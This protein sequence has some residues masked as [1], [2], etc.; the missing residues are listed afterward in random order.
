MATD[1][2]IVQALTAIRADL[3]AFRVENNQRFTRVEEHLQMLNG[4]TAKVET[5]A[6][7]LDERTS[8]MACMQHS[9][10]FG[11]ME[12]ELKM[13]DGDVKSNHDR[14]NVVERGVVQVS[15]QVE[16]VGREVHTVKLRQHTGGMSAKQIGVLVALVSSA[17]A[18][19]DLLVKI[20][21]WAK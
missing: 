20:S 19:L 4:R 15:E 5:L 2:Y 14:I 3:T 7:G 9:E 21:G 11:D 12:M 8:H 10:R 17:V 1:D 6:G 18:A 13:L 16:A